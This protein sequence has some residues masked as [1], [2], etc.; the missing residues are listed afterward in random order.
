[1]IRNIVVTI[2]SQHS[3]PG[4]VAWCV[5]ESSWSP[6]ARRESTYAAWYFPV[7]SGGIDSVLEAA[8][9]AV[10]AA[11]R[12]R[13]AQEQDPRLCRCGKPATHV[14]APPDSSGWAC[15]VPG[16]Q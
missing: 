14:L 4:E 10:V 13:V 3:H 6:A 12:A 16:R 5:R 15:R 11:V 9:H 1:M 2:N 7:P 8:C